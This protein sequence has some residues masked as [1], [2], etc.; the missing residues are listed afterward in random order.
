MADDKDRF[1]VICNYCGRNH[2][3]P[4]G[5]EFWWRAKNNP[6]CGK[7]LFLTSTLC[8]CE[9]EVIEPDAPFRV[10]YHDIEL[11]E[12]DKPFTSF[13]KAAIFYRDLQDDVFV[14][15]V[16]VDNRPNKGGFNSRVSRGVE[17]FIR[18]W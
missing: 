11:G 7:V 14:T 10:C 15:S 4:Q 9:K 12:F 8:G 5:S 16:F 13:V 2:E 17:K 1:W 6:D 18:G 3:V